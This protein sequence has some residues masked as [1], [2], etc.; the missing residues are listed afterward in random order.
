M[1]EYNSMQAVARFLLAGGGASWGNIE[2]I[3]KI[4]SAEFLNRKI[5]YC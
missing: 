2:F 1:Y 5:F 4:F 3:N